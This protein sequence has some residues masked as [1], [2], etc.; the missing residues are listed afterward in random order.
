MA[1][2]LF[3]DRDGDIVAVCADH[4]DRDSDFDPRQFARPLFQGRRLPDGLVDDVLNHWGGRRLPE[5]DPSC[6]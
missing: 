1:A 6:G 5:P 4:V 2:Y 3:R